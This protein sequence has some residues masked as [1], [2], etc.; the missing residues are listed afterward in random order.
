VTDL[1]QKPAPQTGTPKVKG[2]ALIH[3][4]RKF[5]VGA[6]PFVVT[7]ASRPALSAVCTASA[8]ASFNAN[9]SSGDPLSG[10]TCA[11]GPT[12]W[13]AR[14]NHEGANAWL[15]TA[16][17]PSDS[18]RTIL[19]TANLINGNTTN[20]R[21]F[22]TG[23]GAP[24]PTLA[25]ALTGT[26]VVNFRRTG[27]ANVHQAANGGAFC[28]EAV[29]ALLNASFDSTYPNGFGLT[30]AQVISMVQ[31]VWDDVT[32]ADQAAVDAAVN[33]PYNTFVNTHTGSAPCDV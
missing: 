23:T 1:P 2:G 7:L 22:L 9:H 17:D 16:Y 28:A 30:V 6:A 15:G 21:W 13:T 29:A 11:M 5:I 10:Q 24:S 20:N 32:N 3:G 18:F 31:A 14:A 26:V 33:G 27:A 19:G 25:Q 8:G 4:R 12:C